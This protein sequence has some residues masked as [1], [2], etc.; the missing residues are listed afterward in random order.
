MKKEKALD[1]VNDYLVRSI[2][3]FGEAMLESEIAD[4]WSAFEIVENEVQ[5]SMLNPDGDGS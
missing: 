2:N 5:I 1:I 4:I 3:V